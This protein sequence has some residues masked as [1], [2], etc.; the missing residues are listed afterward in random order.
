MNSRVSKVKVSAVSYLNT[1]PFVYGLK[2]GVIKNS[3]D[4]T[5]DY[6]SE[7]A[8]KVLSE[9]SDMGLIPVAAIINRYDFKIVSEYCIGANDSVRTVALF[10][11]SQIENIDTIYLDYQSL[12][13]V[14]LI[15]VLA[16]NLWNKTFEWKPFGPLNSY[17]DILPN[18]GVVAIGDKVFD[19]ESRFT[20]IYDLASEWKRLTG[21]PMVFAVWAS[22]CSMPST[23]FINLLNHSLKHGIDNITAAVD[24]FGSTIIP[25]FEAER[26]LTENISF[27]LDIKKRKAID[28]FS[29][30]S[31][32]FIPKT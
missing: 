6:P 1:A 19:L 10:S 28:V 13:S 9:E 25:K 32:E 3:I 26:Y 7:C 4:L 21:L 22:K 14:T 17:F 29:K 23:E 12:T 2:H 30:L 15:K 18:Q 27:T 20:R 8:R 16:K 5:L 11:N 31:R 24:F